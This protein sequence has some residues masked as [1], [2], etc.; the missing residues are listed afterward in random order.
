M[1]G[2]G[3]TVP[4]HPGDLLCFRPTTLKY[5]LDVDRRE[6]RVEE[7]ALSNGQQP[8]SDVQDSDHVRETEDD[9]SEI[10]SERSSRKES[11]ID[12][13]ETED[14]DSFLDVGIEGGDDSIGDES[15]LQSEEGC[16]GSF[17]EGSEL[18]DDTDEM[19]RTLR[20]LGEAKSYPTTVGAESGGGG[21]VGVGERERSLENITMEDD[22]AEENGDTG[23][24]DEPSSVKRMDKKML[25]TLSGELRESSNKGSA[26]SQW[27]RVNQ[28]PPRAGTPLAE[29]EKPKAKPPPL[30]PLPPPSMPSLV[31]VASSGRARQSVDSVK[32]KGDGEDYLTLLQ[33]SVEEWEEEEVDAAQTARSR[34]RGRGSKRSR[35]S[36]QIDTSSQSEKSKLPNKDVGSMSN[37]PCK[38]GKKS[39]PSL[40]PAPQVTWV[41]AESPLA[42][43]AG[44]IKT[45][46]KY[47]AEVFQIPQLLLLNNEY[48]H[49]KVDR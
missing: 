24:R 49:A 42:S 36:V 44:M 6:R 30:P 13:G 28:V 45:L 31:S 41:A 10:S 43:S 48:I 18:I 4:I 1:V 17:T 25:K 34:G 22:D 33:L 29:A 11:N 3:D 21:N 32:R 16:D 14:E 20:D 26:I 47:D 37:I 40:K 27:R 9:P 8:L 2:V 15:I 39:M 23:Y 19:A 7:S 12:G 35:L 46:L 38:D 5:R